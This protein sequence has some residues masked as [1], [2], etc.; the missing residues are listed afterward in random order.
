M[1]NLPLGCGVNVVQRGLG[2]PKGE[3]QGEASVA[4]PCV[5]QTGVGK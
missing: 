2:G 1:V 3:G 4:C 5:G